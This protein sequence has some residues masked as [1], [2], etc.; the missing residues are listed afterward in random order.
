MG[1]ALVRASVS[2]DPAAHA[3][4]TRPVAA[5]SSLSTSLVSVKNGA[6]RVQETCTEDAAPRGRRDI[7]IRLRGA[8]RARRVA[9]RRGLRSA[10]EGAARGPGGLLLGRRPEV[11][12][13]IP[14]L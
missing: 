8:A 14:F 6:T 7:S 2:I 1:A 10:P 13:V 4:E 12:C 5:A 9:G 11:V 3:L